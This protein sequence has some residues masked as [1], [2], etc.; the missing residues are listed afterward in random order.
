MNKQEIKKLR[1]KMYK[2]LGMGK[3]GFQRKNRNWTWKV[4]EFETLAEEFNLT[5]EEI[6]DI[7][8]GDNV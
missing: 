6:I 5:H 7:M 1:I 3:E 2:H 8:R 4:S